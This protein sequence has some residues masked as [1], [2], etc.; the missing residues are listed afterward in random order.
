MKQGLVSVHW[1]SPQPSPYNDF[2]LAQLSS[3]PGIDLRV[4][5]L[6]RAISAHP[7]KD[8]PERTFPH[9]FKAP[10][11]RLDRHILRLAATSEAFFV[12]AGWREP[13]M[14][15]VENILISRKAPFAIWTDTPT[16][17]AEGSPLK[18]RI[19]RRWLSRLMK[20][21]SFVMGTGTPAMDALQTMGCPVEKLVNF[22]FFVDL[23]LFGPNPHSLPSPTSPTIFLSSGRLVNTLKGFDL[24]LRALATLTNEGLTNFEYR[25]AGEGPDGDE[26]RRLANRL[27]LGDRVRFLGWLESTDAPDFLRGGHVFLHPARRDPFPVVVLEAMA[28]GLPIIGSTSAGSV[29]DRVEDGKNGWV[30]EP[31]DEGGLTQ[32]IRKCLLEPQGLSSMGAAARLTAEQWPVSRGIEEV[33]RMVAHVRSAQ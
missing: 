28:S 10:G 9:R 31:N 7:W 2:L 26:L 32:L 16:T 8:E 11:S 15:V 22:P 20:H 27:G 30:H 13:T 29:R 6:N 14:V 33:T 3:E 5:F 23:D 18:D 25:I 12:I 1:L 24:A 17:A 21:S 19:R 4:H